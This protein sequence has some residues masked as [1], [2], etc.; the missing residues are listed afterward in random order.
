M[1]RYSEAQNKASQRYQKKVYDAINLRLRKDGEPN[2][3]MIADAAK[4]AGESVNGF[5]KTAIAERIDRMD[6]KPIIPD[7]PLPD[8][9]D[10]EHAPP[11]L[12]A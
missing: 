7:E 5:I 3:A 12:W 8:A 9:D 6:Q 1:A 10:I 4:K 11:E 2:A